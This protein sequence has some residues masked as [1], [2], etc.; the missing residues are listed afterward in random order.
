[1]FTK[2]LDIDQWAGRH[3]I[4]RAITNPTWSQVSEEITSLDGESKTMVI[5]T[6]RPESDYYMIVAGCWEGGYMVNATKNQLEFFS[7]VDPDGSTTKRLVFVGGQ[8]G[9][10]EERMFIPLPQALEAARTFYE[11][12]EFDPTL[13]WER[14]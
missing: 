8:D 4:D 9:D 2:H 12:G 3:K 7:I 5:L 11:T 6:D 14:N 1:M 10:Y 13:N